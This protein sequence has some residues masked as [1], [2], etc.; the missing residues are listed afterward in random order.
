MDPLT[1]CTRG[2]VGP[3]SGLDTESRRKSFC[4]CR[5]SNL[6][7]PVVHSFTRH[8]TNW[9]TPALGAVVLPERILRLAS[10]SLL[11]DSQTLMLY[12]SC[13][14]V[15]H[16]FWLIPQT[17][18]Y[19]GVEVKPISNMVQK[20]GVV[21]SRGG[22]VEGEIGWGSICHTFY[23]PLSST[24]FLPLTPTVVFLFLSFLMSRHFN[25]NTPPWVFFQ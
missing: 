16:S 21:S 11:L 23:P 4:F 9:A 24:T 22:N 13:R 25:Y 5:G 1:Q 8:Y 15:F 20:I 2:C 14:T 12:T 19:L 7:R 17:E 6:D 3:G 18:L 10:C